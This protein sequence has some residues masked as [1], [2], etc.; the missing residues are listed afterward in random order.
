[1]YEYEGIVGGIIYGVKHNQLHQAHIKN[2]STVQPQ[3][4]GFSINS[5][6][7]QTELISKLLVYRFYIIIIIPNSQ[8]KNVA[9]HIRMGYI[10]ITAHYVVC[11]SV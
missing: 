4:G 2:V 5:T 8:K 10:P 3:R 6:G 11:V 9:T 7:L 1:M